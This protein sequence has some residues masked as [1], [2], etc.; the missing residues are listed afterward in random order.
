MTELLPLLTYSLV[1]SS[2]PGPNNL[3]VTASGAN[4][5][6]RR[7]LPHIAGISAGMLVQTALTCAGLGSL[8]AAYPVLHAVLRVAGAL[9]LL[10]LAWKLAGSALADVNLAR[11]LSFAQ[12]AAFQAVNPKSW[13]KSVTLAS[14]FMPPALDV[15]S[16][17]VL[18]T[19]ITVA[20]GAPCI[21]VWALFGV[22]I[23]GLLTDPRRRRVFNVIMAATLIALALSFLH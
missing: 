17:T 12:A 18:V 15:A 5:G 9:Y 6:F 14:V 10:V 2:T 21:A 22:A 19:A 3:M 8:F 4:F 13:V 1:M 11:P 23:R 16:G 7:T 20:I